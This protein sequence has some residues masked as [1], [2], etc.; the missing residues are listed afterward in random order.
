MG[1]EK[2]I[3]AK[4]IANPG[5][6]KGAG[7]SAR[8]ENVVRRLMS[9][10]LQVDVVLA[11]PKKKAT[12][13]AKKAV[14]DG[15]KVVIAMGG[16][17]T[18]EAVLRGL[19]GSKARLAILPAGSANNIAKSLGIPEDLDAASDMIVSGPTRKVDI[20]R[21]KNQKKKFYFLE[22]T[23]IGLIA[24]LYPESKEIPKGNLVMLKDAAAKLLHYETRPEVFLT[25]DGE[26]KVKVESMLVT[27]ANTPM[28]GLN[29]M[30]A[31]NASL[32]DGLL[33]I[34][35]Y[36]G[37]SKADLLA[38]FA[39][40]MKERVDDDD[41]IQRYRARKL[42]IK[43]KPRLEVM[44]DGVMLGEGRVRIKLFPRA[45]RVIAPPEGTGFA[46][47]PEP[48]QEAMPA[49]AAPVVENKEGAE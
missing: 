32:R 29:F 12:P 48:K 7:F 6:G 8:L 35:V 47:P 46:Q 24:A 45:L 18:I 22:L 28:T 14:K 40:V 25:M 49:P 34:C 9:S 4:L 30:L 17:G 37:F 3:R 38:Y 31:P 21:V 36:P 43:T 42:K 26:S 41:R 39:K 13:I 16:D 1:K 2:Q 33:D 27:V 23:A 10:G 11:R 15:Y 19:V 44:A 5:A 20:G